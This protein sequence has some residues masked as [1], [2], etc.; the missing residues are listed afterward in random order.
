[1][2]FVSSHA[3]EQDRFDLV[4]QLLQPMKPPEQYV[5][6]FFSRLLELN[7]AVELLPGEEEPLTD[8]QLQKAFYDPLGTIGS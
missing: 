1:M 6:A 2:D 4:N 3:S 5:Q 8:R 7:D